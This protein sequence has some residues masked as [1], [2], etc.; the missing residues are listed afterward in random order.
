MNN[1]TKVKSLMDKGVKIPV[2]ESVFVGEDVDVSRISGENVIIYPG[3]RI[4]GKSTLIMPDVTLGFESPVTLDN[5][6]V[7]Y[8]SRLNGGF[9]Q[10]CV[11]VGQNSFGSGAHVRGGTI[12]EEGA[13][14][15]HTV[16]LKQ[17]IL[18]PFVTLGSVV[19]FCDCLMAGGTSRKD[20]SEVGSSFIHFNYTPNQDKATPSML[21]NVYQ[22]VMLKSRPV[23]LGGQGGLVG[24]CRLPFG[25]VTAAGTIWRKDIE[26]PDRLMFG[27]GMRDAVL[28]RKPGIYS[29][30][31]RLFK[32]NI[33][34]IAGLTSLMSWYVH[35][36][37]LF[38][39][40]LF[41]EHLLMG[42]KQ[43]LEA[44]IDERIKRLHDFVGRLE[45]SK[46][47]LLSRNSGRITAAVEEHDA[48]I[49]QWG[50][51]LTEGW[52]TAQ[53][54]LEK[55]RSVNNPPPEPFLIAVENGIKKSG[56][57]YIKVIQGL[58]PAASAGGSRWLESVEKKLCHENAFSFS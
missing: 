14:A 16:G 6:L 23:F 27:G 31:G 24:P 11:F 44:A 5:V 38:V 57:D 15:A 47:L 55:S 12:L 46:E 53:T 28:E 26:E 8:G 37:H 2:P 54:I 17:T 34:Y 43:T 7:G 50:Y 25:S 40:E 19:N 35:I 22:G 49:Q 52:K 39:S 48:V 4:M 45:T 36:R 9:F 41:S 51:F 29:N 1:Q 58:D 13:S 3:T 33:L 20:H 42:M 21:G 18:F 30:A 32:N 10:K 56:Q